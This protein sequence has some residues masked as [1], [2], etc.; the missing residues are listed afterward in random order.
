M[1][2]PVTLDMVRLIRYQQGQLERLRKNLE[3]AIATGDIEAVHDLRVASRR[4]HEALG[5]MNAVPRLKPKQIGSAQRLLKSIR[6]AYR[7]VRDLD[8]LRLSLSDPAATET[9]DGDTLTWVESVLARRRERAVA[10]ATR[11]GRRSRVTKGLMAL[12]K[13]IKSCATI[14][15]GK[16]P[17]VEERFTSILRQRATD[18]LAADPREEA[19]DLHQTR[20]RIKRMRYCVQLL[21]ECSGLDETGLMTEL[22]GMQGLLGHW[23]DRIVAARTLG[24]LA[25]RRRLL[26]AQTTISAKLFEYAGLQAQAALDERKQG[27]ERWSPLTALIQSALPGWTDQ[28]PAGVN[29]CPADSEPESAEGDG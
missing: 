23:N 3:R 9:L 12:K 17:E 1:G 21:E 19:T 15:E 24:R 28:K 29:P 13:Q 16:R 7:R 4:L 22:T 26:A 5:L 10:A 14:M 6:K 27:L 20:I 18:L 11:M 8:V 25:G 2:K